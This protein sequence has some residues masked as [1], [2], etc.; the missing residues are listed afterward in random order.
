MVK[1]LEQDPNRI[2]HKEQR[3]DQSTKALLLALSLSKRSA[4]IVNLGNTDPIQLANHIS[5]LKNYYHVTVDDIVAGITPPAFDA[6]GLIVTGY[7]KKIY[8]VPDT[9]YKIQHFVRQLSF[10]V[11]DANHPFP[12]LVL[13]NGLPHTECLNNPGLPWYNGPFQD[14]SVWTLKDDFSLIRHER[15]LQL[16]GNG[17]VKGK[18]AALQTIP[19]KLVI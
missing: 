10:N 19:I 8:K 6:N 18:W 17:A 15:S 4:A 3:L 11:E 1:R 12:V 14:D 5:S 2:D 9:E 13:S 7:S 16:S